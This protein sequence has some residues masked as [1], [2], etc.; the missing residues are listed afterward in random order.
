MAAKAFLIQRHVQLPLVRVGLGLKQSAEW[1]TLRTVRT[2]ATDADAVIEQLDALVP[3]GVVRGD[4]LYAT[5]GSEVSD[6]FDRIMA[7]SAAAIET[8]R[9]IAEAGEAMRLHQ[10]RRPTWVRVTCSIAAY[11]ILAGWVYLIVTVAPMVAVLIL[12]GGAPVLILASALVLEWVIRPTGV[13]RWLLGK[14]TEFT[15]QKHES[16]R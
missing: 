10:L 8:E 5:K 12:I 13:I 9:R 14:S 1:E 6:A 16:A 3:R 7:R 2:D 11:S 15:D 4:G